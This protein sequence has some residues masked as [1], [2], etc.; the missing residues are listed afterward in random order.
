[1]LTVTITTTSRFGDL[2]DAL[3]EILLGLKILVDGSPDKTDELAKAI[4]D[5]F[6]GDFDRF[7]AFDSDLS[8]ASGADEL[9]VTFKP[10]EI[11]LGFLAAVRT[12][13]ADEV[14]AFIHKNTLSVNGATDTVKQ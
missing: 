3:A 4:P 6:D 7:I 13:D 5:F 9:R 8:A 12:G 14:L 1:M 2:K 11:L 10:S